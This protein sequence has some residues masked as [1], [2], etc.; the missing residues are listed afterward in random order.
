MSHAQPGC[1]DDLVPQVAA[2][3]QHYR[4]PDGQRGL[5]E[6]LLLFRQALAECG[7]AAATAPRL[8]SNAVLAAGL[9]KLA[10]QDSAAADLLRLRYVHGKPVTVVANELNFAETTIFRRRRE[11]TELLAA[12]LADLDGAARRRRLD[13]VERWLGAPTTLPLVGVDEQVEAL[14]VLLVSARPPWLAS[15]EGI[16]GI[17]KTALAGAL[18]RR[19][20]ASS[21][22]DGF[23]W[24]SAQPALLDASGSIRQRARPALTQVALVTALLEQ[25]APEEAAGRL[26]HAEAAL[27]LLHSVLK[28]AAYLVVIDNLETVTDLQTL[29]PLLHSLANPSKFLLTSRQRLVEDRDVYFYGVPELSESNALALVRSAGALHNVAALAAASDAEL[30]PLYS[31]V[32]GNPLALLLVVGQLHL[33]D[34]DTL[35][36]DLQGARGV[37]VE[38]L[39]TFI[40]RRAWE[41]LDELQ[42]QVLLAMSLVQVNGDTLSFIAATSGLPA[43]GA[44]GGITAALQ[45]LQALNLVYTVGESATR[46]YAIHSLTRTFLYE[47]VARWMHTP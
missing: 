17:G 3:L 38:N 30:R 39:Y 8:A 16:G 32:G 34:L 23:A 36:S 6:S 4:D 5:L 40:Y 44:N 7:P 42:R 20:A 21:S 11:A 37:T 1:D 15:I 28:R 45:Q 29:L 19:V 35:L 41:N 46:R 47:Q 22:F 10:A 2:A 24:V 43:G 18:L 25:L 33:R 13:Q 26:G 14:A 9:E 12:V 27:E 31:V